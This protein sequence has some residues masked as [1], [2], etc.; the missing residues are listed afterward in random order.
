MKSTIDSAGRLVIPRDI[1]RE[2]GLRPGMPLQVRWR[3]GCIE[4]E[5]EPL[6][7]ALERKGRLTVAVPRRQ[8]PELGADEVESV[9]RKLRH[10][11][12]GRK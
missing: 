7:V 10:E 9:R 8:T 4:I 12:T 3:N 2:A 6:P 1:R 5:P 11:R